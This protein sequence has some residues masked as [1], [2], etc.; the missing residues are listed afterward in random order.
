MPNMAD[1]PSGSSE[2][3]DF[4]AS[5]GHFAKWANKVAEG[6]ART[7]RLRHVRRADGDDERIRAAL[8]ELRLTYEQLSVAEV[9][10][11][12]QNDELI[13]TRA[14]VEAERA[15][16]SDLFHHAPLPYVVTDENGTIRQANMAARRL[17]KTRIDFLEGVP[18]VV[19]TEGECRDRVRSCIVGLISGADSAEVAFEVARKG[20]PGVPVVAT[21][22]VSRNPDGSVQEIRWLLIDQ[23]PARRRDEARRTR[24]A[25]LEALVAERTAEL[26]R[27]EELKDRLI[28]IV[29]HE[30]R[31][32]LT[33]IA[34]F[35]ELLAMGLRGP[36]SEEQR[37]D[38]ERIHRAY[39]HMARVVDDL[40]SYNKVSGGRMTFD[41]CDTELNGQLQ[42]VLELVARDAAGHGVR[43][44]I[45]EAPRDAIIHADPERV[46]QILVNLLG[47]AVK[48]TPPGGAVSVRTRV[49]RREVVIEVEDTGR[50][51]PER[52]RERIFEP[53]V[54]LEED[55]NVAGSGLGLA[56]SREMAREMGGD[57]SVESELGVG[58]C[59]TLR[60][61]RS[62]DPPRSNQRG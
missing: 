14:L 23:R 49:K 47:N 8:D 41:V 17:V 1:L 53:F 6:R 15:R 51:I 55:R 45:D 21:A 32:P 20:E 27:A 39:E 40:L 36:I 13:A 57:L 22:S 24:A 31:T 16:Y 60:L 48:F 9:E 2:S 26:Q 18:I 54:R 50:G 35:T 43:L 52:E 61:P 29:S 58:S 59:F 28:A 19:F 7:A 4:G 46:R 38:I 44:S 34:G 11:R 42:L 30:L 62:V 56:I 12:A 25:K 10:L 3:A 37:T 5:D 33:A